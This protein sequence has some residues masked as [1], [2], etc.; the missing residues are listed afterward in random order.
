MPVLL[1]H[2]LVLCGK[3]L[4]RHIMHLRLT[5]PKANGSLEAIRS[6]DMRNLLL[7]LRRTVV[8][9]GSIQPLPNSSAA[10]AEAG[11]QLRFEEGEH[12]K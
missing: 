4:L 2:N 9:H 1:V 10:G 5:G 12:S 3:V 11:M 6:P 8:V 7:E